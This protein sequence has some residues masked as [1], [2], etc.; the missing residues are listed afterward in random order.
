VDG[1]G[2]VR[3]IRQDR[4]SLAFDPWLSRV[5]ALSADAAPFDGDPTIYV[6]RK[7]ADPDEPVQ[8]VV[9]VDMP[10]REMSRQQVKRLIAQLTNEARGVV[11]T[12]HD[13]PDRAEAHDAQGSAVAPPEADPEASALRLT[14]RE[15]EVMQRLA[16]GEPAKRIAQQLGISVHTCRDYIKS[17]HNKLGVRSQVELVIK[18]QRVGLIGERM[19]PS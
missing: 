5:Q 14:C 2:E 4:H 15:S 13:E 6:R 1:W 18:A 8:Y 7:K 11:F 10:G 17:L 12:I 9:V 16:N 3:Q 19:W